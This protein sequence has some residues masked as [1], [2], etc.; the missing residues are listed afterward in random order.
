LPIYDRPTKSLLTD[1]AKANLKPDQVFSKSDVLPWFAEHYP[2]IKRA[3]VVMHL[4]SMSINN[5]GRKHHPSVKLG[6]GHDLFFK[7]GPDQYR[8]W[9]PEK[10][11][12]PLYKADIDKMPGLVGEE[13]EEPIDDGGSEFA[14][15][16][17]LQNYLAKNLHRI[18]AGLRLY[19]EEE[20][21]G[22]E[23]AAG[24]RYIDILAVD[25]QGSYVVIELKVSRGY[26]RVIGQLL[27]YMSWVERNMETSKPVRGIIVA[28]EITDDLRLA[29]SR[30]AGVRLIEYEIEFKLRPV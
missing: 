23:F 18:E 19:E 20:I 4:E 1:W 7:L 2:K 16:R 10:D 13:I 3:T 24:G 6:S 9:D 27:R 21:T 11:G 22:L 8:L 30:I 14:Y 29:A 28:K 12:K 25:A 17:D 15:E 5:R 26:D